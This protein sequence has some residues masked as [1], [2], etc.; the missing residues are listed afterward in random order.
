MNDQTTKY[1]RREMVGGASVELALWVGAG[2]VGGASMVGGWVGL[3][4]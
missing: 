4:Q 3:V 2:M 1:Q